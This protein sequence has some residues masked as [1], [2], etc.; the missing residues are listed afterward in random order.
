MLVLHRLVPDHDPFHCTAYTS[1]LVRSLMPAI[2][3]TYIYARPRHAI[4]DSIHNS[5]PRFLPM[6]TPVLVQIEFQDVKM[7][8]RP[9]LPLVLKGLTVTIPAG[10]KAG[11]VG[12]TGVVLPNAM[13]AC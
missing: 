11:V 10:S 9:G 1:V 12:R 2:T 8:Y 13:P 6:T 4:R 7:R 3:I 5:M